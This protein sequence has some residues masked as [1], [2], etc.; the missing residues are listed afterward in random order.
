M[1]YLSLDI[2]TFSP[3][4]LPT[5]GVYKYATHPD[6]DLLLFA[7]SV[8]GG[9]VNVVSVATGETIPAE[10]LTALTDPNIIKYA[11]NA[12]F[13]RVCLSAYLTN[14]GHQLPGGFINPA[15]WRCTMV[16]ASALGL[17]R[18]L[19]AA[20][21]ALGLSEQKNT[22]GKHL[23][24]YFCAP[25]TPTTPTQQELFDTTDMGH[26]N[27]PKGAPEKWLDFIEY[28]RQDV[29]V[30]NKLRARLEKFPIHPTTWAEY[31]VDQRI[32][33]RGIRVD[34]RLAAQAVQADELHRQHCLDEA[35]QLTGLDNPASPTQLQTWL[36]QQGCVVPDMR[37]DTISQALADTATTG[38]V[39]RVLELRQDLS[40]SSVKKY[41]AVLNYAHGDDEDQRARGLIQFYGAGRTGRWAGRGIQVQ[42]LPRNYL[43]DLVEARQL[44][45]RGCH[46]LAE[47]LY[48]PLPD[49][50]S[51]L[52]RTVFIPS[53]GNRFIV[54]DY[55]AIEARVLAWLAG[56][57]TTLDAFR[58]GEDIY[59][60]TA[61][62]MFGVPVDKHGPNGHLRQKGKVAVLACGYQGGV[63]AI[64]AMG[65]THMGLSEPEM[66]N[67]VDMWRDANPHI[68]EFWHQVEE[69]A[70]HVISTGT[71]RK[72]RGVTLGC[73]AGVLHITLP[74]GRT[75]HY[76]K[77]HQAVNRFGNP[78]IG[79]WGPNTMGA[80]TRQ[81]T[82]GGK[83]VENIT[84]AVARDLLGHALRVVDANNHHTVMHIHDEIVVDAPPTTTVGEICHLMAQTPPWA[85]GLPVTADGYECPF[86][87]KD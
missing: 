37:K 60:A 58:R 68:V 70:H 13:E 66:Q 15:G 47:A 45:Y 36:A 21:D 71:T 33:D 17:P 12:N 24:K 78:S 81:E 20:A 16:W 32:N 41:Q 72:V 1:R 28:N 22:D 23:I 39:R 11:Y 65:G 73:T 42:N 86:Y 62:H 85:D 7:Y 10:I 76:P 69:A 63:G 82:Y 80:F 44:I 75:L 87:Q 74:S 43:P 30:E 53:E 9:E 50:L 14:L 83:L 29:I 51:Q 52:V 84:Q 18:S 59:C 34:T 40:R 2:E 25:T 38:V 56:Q 6:F 5:V 35:R 46:D 27:T 49:T 67:I 55:S 26:R 79:Y 57:T 3:E 48:S 8:D 64:K 54:A 31:W 4:P 77:V 19:A 61:T